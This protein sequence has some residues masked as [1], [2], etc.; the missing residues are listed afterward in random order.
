MT[1][2]RP[3]PD[4]RTLALYLG[5]W[6]DYSR[7]ARLS[8][9]AIGSA[10]GLTPQAFSR[11]VKGGP[12]SLASL[13]AFMD[14]MGLHGKRREGLRRLFAASQI[15]DDEIRAELAAHARRLLGDLEPPE[16]PR[17]RRL[18]APPTQ[19]AEI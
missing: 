16:P 15:D 7:P 17:D 13:T 6:L 10:A 2:P 19:L 18:R 14:G 3:V 12:T 4:R 9:K 8:H 1:A 5:R 11:V